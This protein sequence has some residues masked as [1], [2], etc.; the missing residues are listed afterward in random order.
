MSFI[1]YRN[2]GGMRAPT[3]LAQSE[4]R[5]YKP[6]SVVFASN[7]IETRDRLTVN[8]SIAERTQILDQYIVR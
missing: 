3:G 8:V 4:R 5:F 7:Q 2:Y 1:I 6:F